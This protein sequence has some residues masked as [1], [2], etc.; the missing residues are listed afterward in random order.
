MNSV[1]NRNEPSDSMKGWEF[2]DNSVTMS[3]S[4]RALLC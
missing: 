2:F 4:G 1:M 3:L